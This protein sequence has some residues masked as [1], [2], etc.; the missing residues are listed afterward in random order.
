MNKRDQL[1]Q[2]LPYC[3]SDIQKTRLE[4]VIKHGKQKKAAEALGCS[5]RRVSESINIVKKHARSQGFQPTGDVFKPIVGHFVKGES[6]LVGADGVPRMKW[7]KTDTDKELSLQLLQKAILEAFD[8]YKGEAG[9]VPPPE[10]HSNKDLL[11]SIPIG[12]A[13]L[14]MLAWAEDAGEDFDLKKADKIYCQAFSRMIDAAPNAAECLIKDMGDFLHRNDNKNQTPQSGNSL[15][16]DGRSI[17]MI[18][19][20]VKILIHAIN[21]A[22]KKFPVVRLKNVIGNHSPEGEQMLALAL[23]LYFHNEPR[24]IVEQSTNK[25]W[26]Y[27]WGKTLIGTCHGDGVKHGELPMIMAADVPEMWGNTIFR[28]WFIGH[29]HHQ[30]I[31]EYQG[32]TVESVNTITPND[33]WH[34][35]AGYRSRKNIKLIVFH[36]KYGEIERLT[37]D[38]SMLIDGE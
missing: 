4:A 18:R 7:V 15:D 11:V 23:E 6:A 14:G 13:H 36:K 32:C 20:A 35:G 8:E 37:K 2:L 1:K 16:C 30:Q 31:K 38:I 22:L 26:Y 12:D 5:P 28:Y 34:H 33:A 21:E 9:Q 19:I 10:V 25:F 24:V 27:Q 17:K 3:Q 29:I